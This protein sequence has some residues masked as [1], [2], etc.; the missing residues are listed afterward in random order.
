MAVRLPFRRRVPPGGAVSPVQ[1]EK[2]CPKFSKNG[3]LKI[4][5]SSER[6]PCAMEKDVIKISTDRIKQQT[7]CCADRFIVISMVSPN[8][9]K[10]LQFLEFIIS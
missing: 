7:P 6:D 2:P 9:K 1:F 3:P 10:R 5:C 8:I 4:I